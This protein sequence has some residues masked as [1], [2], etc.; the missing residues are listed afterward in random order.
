MEPVA[1]RPCLAGDVPGR[2]AGP[3][4]GLARAGRDQ[5]QARDHDARHLP[6]REAHGS[7]ATRAVSGPRL[8][9]SAREGRA[10][11]RELPRRSGPAPRPARPIGAGQP[12]RR[13]GDAEGEPGSRRSSRPSTRAYR[14]ARSG[15]RFAAAGT[16][17]PTRCPAGGRSRRARGCWGSPGASAQPRW[18]RSLRAPTRRCGR[19]PPRHR[20]RRC[21][22]RARRAPCSRRRRSWPRATSVSPRVRL[23]SGSR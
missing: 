2:A 3:R 15:G 4:V 11:R 17:A 23:A 6:A 13:E 1:G 22:S 7:R 16:T 18:T 19:S 14:S 20:R 10:V 5:A 12:H 21:S 8:R 9:T